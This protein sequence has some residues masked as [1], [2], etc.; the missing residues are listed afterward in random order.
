MSEVVR[1]E[2]RVLTNKQIAAMGALA[3]GTTVNAAADVAGV[4]VRTVRRWCADADFRAALAD[5]ETALG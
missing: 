4:D 5:L 1:T 3:T 2:K